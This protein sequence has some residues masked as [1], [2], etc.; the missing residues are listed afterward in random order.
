MFGSVPRLYPIIDT[1]I[2]PRSVE[3]LLEQFAAAGLTWVQL[4]NKQAVS[5]ELFEQAC[6]FVELSRNHRLTSIINDRADIALFSGADG[7]HLGQEDLPVTHARKILG[8][9]KIIGCSTHNL[10]Q[11][12]EAEASAAD[13]VAIGP[14]FAT[15][16]KE[17]ADPIVSTQQLR[18]I[19]AQVK[20]PLVAIG[21][22]TTQNA[23]EI[24]AL[25]LESVAVIRDLLQAESP[26]EQV[27]RFLGS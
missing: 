27:R 21:G 16:S 5:R 20:K 25:G 4:R 6:R 1:Q 14:V 22:I 24:W 23:R 9:D 13:Y 18:H 10:T 26:G 12:L 19:R 7:V 17:N 11:A 8:P 3:F 2:S 15:T